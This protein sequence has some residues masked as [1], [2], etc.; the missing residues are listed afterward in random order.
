MAPAP[1]RQRYHESQVLTAAPEQLVVM[2][3]DGAIRFCARAEA[4]LERGNASEA[5]ESMIRAQRIVLEL[6]CALRPEENPAISQ[7]LS[8]LYTFMYEQL[9]WANVHA[10]A[11]KIQTVSKLLGTLREGW[12]EAIDKR[13]KEE[14]R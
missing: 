3:D 4:A 2:L 8:A 1:S 10:D 6:L 13:K 9:V 11:G 5:G 7:N 14:V 12:A